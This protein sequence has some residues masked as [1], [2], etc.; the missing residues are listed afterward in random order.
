MACMDITSTY[1]FL[2]AFASPFY[3]PEAYAAAFAPQTFQQSPPGPSPSNLSPVLKPP[4]NTPATPFRPLSGSGGSPASL[5]HSPLANGYDS[6]PMASEQ[7]A[8][9]DE[10]GYSMSGGCE[11]VL[12]DGT[13]DFGSLASLGG[14]SAL[15][16]L[17]ASTSPTAPTTATS[18]TG[19]VVTMDVPSP[20]F[21]LPPAVSPVSPMAASPSVGQAPTPYASPNAPSSTPSAVASARGSPAY[22]GAP[23]SGV[24]D[25]A[26]SAD[27]PMVTE[28]PAE[29]N[30]T[31]VPMP[32]TSTTEAAYPTI[33]SF[34]DFISPF[35]PLVS[36]PEASPDAAAG[37]SLSVPGPASRHGSSSPGGDANLA[38]PNIG[39]NPNTGINTTTSPNISIGPNTNPSPNASLR[40]SLGL[41]L[42]NMPPP[43]R[44]PLFATCNCGNVR[45]TVRREPGYVL[46]CQCGCCRRFSGGL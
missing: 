15:A 5:A 6:A 43:P 23:V 46:V 44:L 10:V 18:E 1:L 25:I 14:L 28:V 34:F 3:S 4:H 8:Q 38:A 27:G 39:A 42:N 29:S 11:A 21:L 9:N 30:G 13:E 22:T 36:G 17:L 2:N 32:D 33:N 26:M 31:D 24:N 7:T 41:G 19:L 40:G 20:G 16:A 45:V 35:A 12:P 37:P